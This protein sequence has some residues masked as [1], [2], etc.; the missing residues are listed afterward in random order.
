M[1]TIKAKKQ[2]ITVFSNHSLQKDM[3]VEASVYSD[4]LA[5]HKSVG[6]GGHSLTHVPT[7]CIILTTEAMIY[8]SEKRSNEAGLKRLAR[9]ILSLHV[10]LNFDNRHK[11]PSKAQKALAGSVTQYR[12]GKI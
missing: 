3:E 4:L 12:H 9:Y 8:S 2:T 5:V 10:D 6:R 11:M 1:T 7:G